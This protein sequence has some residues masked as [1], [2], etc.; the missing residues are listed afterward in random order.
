LKELLEEF[1]RL[2]KESNSDAMDIFV[3]ILT[4]WQ[5]YTAEEKVAFINSLDHDVLTALGTVGAMSM[6]NLFSYLNLI[7]EGIEHDTMHLFC[8]LSAWRVLQK[9]VQL[10]LNAADNLEYIDRTIALYGNLYT[11]RN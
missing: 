8:S 3:V 11:R 9:M 10:D 6:I 7:L 1:M 2:V 5:N 4:N